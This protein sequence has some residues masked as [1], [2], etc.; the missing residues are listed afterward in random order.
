MMYVHYGEGPA[1]KEKL[2]RGLAALGPGFLAQLCWWCN[3]TTRHEFESCDVCANDRAYGTGLGLLLCGKPA[4]VSVVN[5][6]LIAAE[7]T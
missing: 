5:Q 7:G 3:G 4:P 1:H 6:V 2:V